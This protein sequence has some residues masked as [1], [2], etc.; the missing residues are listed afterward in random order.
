VSY[1]ETLSDRCVEQALRCAVAAD[2]WAL[3]GAHRA[4]SVL[5]S[6]LPAPSPAN[7]ATIAAPRVRL[8]AF[9]GPVRAGSDDTYGGYPLTHK[10]LFLA[11]L[12]QRACPTPPP[13]AVRRLA[14]VDGRGESSRSAAAGRRN[15]PRALAQRQAAAM[16]NEQLQNAAVGD[17]SSERSACAD[18]DGRRVR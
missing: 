2:C 1:N 4:G 16:W 11:I 7:L 15:L 5:G 14:E 17:L 18:V 8:R 9:T 6:P 12:Q 3:H 13:A 10:L